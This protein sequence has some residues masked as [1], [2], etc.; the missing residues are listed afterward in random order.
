MN[1]EPSVVGVIGGLG[2]EAMAD[3]A[4]KIDDIPDS[5]NHSYIFY[6]NSRLAYKP[7]ELNRVWKPT[8]D[9]ELRR[10]ATAVHTVRIMQYLG[11]HAIGL[12]CNSAHKLFRKIMSDT[13]VT[14]IDMLNETANSMKNDVGTVL[15]L[16]VTDL[17]ESGLYQD[18]LRVPGIAATK[19]S[20]ENQNKI[21]AAIYDSQF[22]IKTARITSRAE[23]LICEVIRDEYRKQGCRKIV[24]GCTEL[25]LA[26][27]N[28]SCRRFKHRGMLPVEIEVIDASAELAR[29]L[30]RCSGKRQP[31]PVRPENYKTLHTDWFAPAA[32]IVEDLKELVA[33]QKSIFTFTSRFLEKKNR[34]ITGSYMHL[35][36]LYT[37]GEITD[38]KA[39]LS[40][41][42]IEIF[43]HD[44]TLEQQLQ[45]VFEQHFASL[46]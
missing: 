45:S 11:C 21:M 20:R 1:H 24:L 33:I 25:P 22:G 8:D 19:P 46:D 3:L 37:V 34:S 6:G 27:N 9:P 7:G 12:A 39:R 13:P 41:L 29:A 10:H 26:L 43:E 40:F 36:T 44:S 23:S 5:E 31:T 30:A 32:F 14:F 16:G 28:E 4:L 42:K 17:V 2:N 15:I 35:P 38:I 18:A